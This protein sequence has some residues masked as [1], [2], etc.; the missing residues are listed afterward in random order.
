MK[1]K[2]NELTIDPEFAALIPPLAPEEREQLERNILAD[3]CR[4][5][6]TAWGGVIVDGHNRYEICTRH[7]IPFDTIQKD[8]ADRDEAM[9]WMDANQLGRRN[10]TPD[11]FTLLLGRRYNRAKRQGQRTDLTSPQSEEKLTSAER[12]A[13]QHGVS[14]ATVERAGQ[15]A[16]AVDKLQLGAEVVSG[17]VDSTRK[18]VIQAAS[19]L[20]E[21]P[22]AEQV[23]EAKKHVHVA[24]NSGNNEWY[25]P[26]EYIAAATA[27]MG[28]IDLDPASSPKANETVGAAKFY[29]AEDDGRENE[30]AGNVWMN[31]PYAQPLIADFSNKIAESYERG[32]VSSACVLV[33]N[34]TETSWFQRMLKCAAGVCFPRARIRFLD[35]N[36]KPGAPLQ[37]QAVIYFG[38]NPQAFCD[39]F[40]GFGACL[41]K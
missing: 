18:A 8:F 2:P 12:I 22:T 5:P 32:D 25:T 19:A 35:P 26:A 20:P 15:F 10:L 39:N 28:C 30:W 4:D 6:L 27:L 3:G 40:G 21:N 14:R 34:A 23:E 29:T 38:N 11:A 33:N 17:R 31:P 9:D 16:E 13:E 7:G 37:G 1:T 24:K 36:G 41:T